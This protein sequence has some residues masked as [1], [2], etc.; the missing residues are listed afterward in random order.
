M[1]ARPL[2]VEPHP[3]LR[4]PARKVERFTASV[5]RLAG[6]MIETM[7][8]HDGIGLAAPQV[9]ESLQLFVASPGQQPGRELVV[10]NPV[11]V[12]MRGRAKIVEGC[13]SI[14]DIWER[15]GRSARVRMTGQDLSGAPIE[16]E[17]EGLLAIIVQHE[18]DHL[19][20]TLFIDRVSWL[21]RRRA[22]AKY[23]R[24]QASA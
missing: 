22:M 1:S 11:M 21:R 3:V 5:R 9:G 2:C 17:A 15:V 7:Y 20:G 24:A 12:A 4:Q 14:P 13:L 6:E 18:Y 10:A 23:R 19:Q 16:L 8:A